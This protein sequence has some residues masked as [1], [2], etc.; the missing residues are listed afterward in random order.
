MLES[1]ERYWVSFLDSPTFR[2]FAG[3]GL[4][5]RVF[6]SPAYRRL[7][8]A[9]NYLTSYHA[10]LV[11]PAAFAGVQTFCAF[12]GHNKSGTSMIGSL[13]DAHPEAVVADEVDVLKYVEAGF[14]REQIF[15]LLLRGSRR[16]RLKG[17]VTARRLQAYSWLVPGQWQGRFRQVRVI[18]D[19]TAGT[20]TRKLG[21]DPDLLDRMQAVM[22]SIPVRFI[23]VVRNPFDPISLIMIRGRRTFENAIDHYFT[24]AA[25]V[26]RL[27]RKVGRENI[28][29]VRYEAFIRQP[30]A[31]LAG[32]C[33]FLGLAAGADYL[34][35]CAAILHQAPEK[36]RMRVPWDP[37]W[38]DVVESQIRRFDF[39]SGY[40]YAD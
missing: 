6:R 39:L 35:D 29:V 20:T 30:E 9:N 24:N 8:L 34:Q 37:H 7:L 11:Q 1:L 17:R 32:V 36:S 25:H 33:D 21:R 14:E 2:R 13:L 28:H 5:Q 10:R 22:G 23:L 40:T 27:Q 3:R 26:A 15:H 12:I 4:G 31:S 16:E 19:G 18:G 38:I